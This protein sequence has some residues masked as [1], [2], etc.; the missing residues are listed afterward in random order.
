MMGDQI[1]TAIHCTADCNQLTPVFIAPTIHSNG[2]PMPTAKDGYEEKG[3][4]EA[5]L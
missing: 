3:K 4:E 1:P 2:T 5:D